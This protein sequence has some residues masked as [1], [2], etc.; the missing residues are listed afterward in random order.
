MISLKDENRSNQGYSKE[1]TDHSYPLNIQTK[2]HN[3]IGRQ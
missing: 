3:V 1:T 2:P